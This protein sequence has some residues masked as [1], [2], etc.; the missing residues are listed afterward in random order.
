MILVIGATGQLGTAIVRKLAAAKQPV[1][2]FVRDG[3]NLRNLETLDVELWF[4]NLCD[5]ENVEVACEGVD[6]VIATA[7]ALLPRNGDCFENVEGTGYHNLIAACQ[8]AGVAQFIFVSLPVTPFDKEICT[9]QYKR[10]IEKE[11][12]ASELSYTIVRASLFMDEWFALLGSSIPLRGAKSHTLRRP[13]WFSRLYMNLAGH[14]VEKRGLAIIPG[15]GDT[16]HAFVSLDDV[17]TFMVK[18]IGHP[19]AQNKI[20]HLAGPEILTW[21][22]AVNIFSRVLGKPVHPIHAPARMFRLGRRALGLF[23]ESAGNIMGLNWAVSQSGTPYD[24]GETASFF[25]SPRVTAEQFLRR[26]ASLWAAAQRR[27]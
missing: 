24:P 18:C 25:E 9:F 20:F 11:L 7:N 1:R 22:D 4:G 3:S 27:A 14:F 6:T 13:F 8:R 21:D 2:A 10:Q 19:Q 15:N 12:Q 5:V 26:K 16:R 23:S 17:A